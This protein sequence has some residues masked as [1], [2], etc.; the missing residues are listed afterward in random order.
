MCSQGFISQ[1]KLYSADHLNIA[2]A[3]TV[4]DLASV[5]TSHLSVVMWLC[6]TG[7]LGTRDAVA[8]ALHGAIYEK[9]LP[10]IKYLMNKAVEHI[11]P[12]EPFREIS[13]VDD[14][15]NGL[16]DSQLAISA[17]IFDTLFR[18]WL[19]ESQ[20][21]RAVEHAISRCSIL[22]L[23][24]LQQRTDHFDAAHAKCYAIDYYTRC[25]SYDI[26]VPPVVL[27]DT[28][29]EQMR[30]IGWLNAQISWSRWLAVSCNWPDCT[31]CGVIISGDQKPSSCW[32]W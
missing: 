30:I 2:G 1:Q 21:E 7:K 32:C 6:K 10:M 23:R 28:H 12:Y 25:C 15:I 14:W 17:Y 29:P 24:W 20:I 3:S 27:A 18:G 31:H 5:A 26:H 13:F 22:T 11:Q 9:N 19:S 4:E 16:I 8:S